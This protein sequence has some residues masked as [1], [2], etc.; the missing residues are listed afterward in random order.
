M[1][2]ALTELDRGIAF[3]IRWFVII[4]LMAMLVLLALGIFVRLVPVFS[5]SGYDEVIEF[6]VVWMV[7]V[8]AV[9]L[10]REGTLFKVELIHVVG[11]ARL[12]RTTDLL[13]RLLM[14]AF[15]IAFLVE[16]WEF[17]AGSIE[18][19]PFLFVS[20]Q[21]WY[22]AMPVAGVLMTAYGIAGVARWWFAPPL[23]PAQ[24]TAGEIPV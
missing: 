21:P 2:H 10:W 14:L 7:F 1:L 4:A 5:M 19:M 9:A 16:G 8:G 22:A 24:P 18:T 20:K 15:A 23:V 17:T 12:V 6:L 11:S 13:A 3:L